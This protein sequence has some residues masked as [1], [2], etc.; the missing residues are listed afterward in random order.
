M[1]TKLSKYQRLIRV[2]Q[3]SFSIKNYMKTFQPDQVTRYH[4]HFR[5]DE[6]NHFDKDNEAVNKFIAEEKKLYK[7][8]S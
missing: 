1:L 5:V 4:G 7:K 8:E 2:P 3:V 6:F